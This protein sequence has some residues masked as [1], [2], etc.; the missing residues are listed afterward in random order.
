M[1]INTVLQQM[2]YMGGFRKEKAYEK[3]AWLIPFAM[4]IALL[5]GVIVVFIAPRII[6][7]APGSAF[8]SL[9]GSTF[10]QMLALSPGV[11]SYIYYLIRTFAFFEAGLLAFL[12]VVSATAYR[13]GER[14]AWYLTWLVPA[15]FA[16]DLPYE[17]FVRGVPF[18]DVSSII[19][20]AI[21][22]V[23][24]LLP[25]RKFFPKKQPG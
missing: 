13:R 20:V 9:T 6:I 3:Y 24:L 4:G 18:I 1:G 5:I 2:A 11:A 16:L 17:Y 25:Y 12:A 22:L 8:E 10:G 7:D 23:G 15:L 21:L 14:W 19:F